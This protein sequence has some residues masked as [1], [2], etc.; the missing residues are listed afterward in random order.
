VS[1]TLAKLA[2]M[3]P[4]ELCVLQGVAMQLPRQSRWLLGEC[5]LVQIKR[6]H[7]NFFMTFFLNHPSGENRLIT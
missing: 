1:G 6:V 3:M 2:A 5:L 4:K 7:H